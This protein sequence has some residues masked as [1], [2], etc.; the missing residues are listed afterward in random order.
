MDNQDSSVYDNLVKKI[1]K[2]VPE[3]EMSA[4]S[5]YGGTHCH[6]CGWNRDVF[7]TLPC[8]RPITLADC[9]IAVSENRSNRVHLAKRDIMMTILDY[10]EFRKDFSNQSARFYEWFHDVLCNKE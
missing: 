3:I 9:M 1:V 8:R 7:G 6:H 5:Y 4:H 2:A 10:W